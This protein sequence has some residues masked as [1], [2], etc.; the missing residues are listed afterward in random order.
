MRA[1]SHAFSEQFFHRE[2][3]LRFTVKNLMRGMR[4]HEMRATK[5]EFY[6][7]KLWGRSGSQYEGYFGGK[8]GLNWAR[9]L[10]FSP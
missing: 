6:F 7:S 3:A 1:T 8:Q 10:K 2:T 4:T 9:K 5:T